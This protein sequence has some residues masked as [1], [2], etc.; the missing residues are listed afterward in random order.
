[1]KVKLL[2]IISMKARYG[3]K[4]ELVYTD[5]NSLILLIETEDV[6]KD[7]SEMH[8]HFDFSDYPSNH[9]LVKSL[10]EGAY[11]RNTK[12]PRK[13]KDE[14]KGKVMWKITA[15]YPKQYSYVLADGKTDRR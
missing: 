12:V 10:P 1:M 9:E 13:F 5:T 14:C 8:E 15:L 2:Y 11:K 4:V 6:Y 3:D 7:M